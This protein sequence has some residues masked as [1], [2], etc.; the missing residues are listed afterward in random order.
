MQS[1]AGN[2]WAHGFH[3]YGPRV[4]DAAL[5]LI[6]KEAEACDFLGGFVLQQSMAGGTGAGL[7]TYVAQALRDEYHSSHIVNC[8][9]WPYE[10]GE[11]IVQSYNTLLTLSH[12]ADLSD[13]IVL[14]Q[15]EALHRLC[16]KLYNIQRPSFTDMNA[17]A[18]RALA[19]VLLPSSHRPAGGK[20]LQQPAPGGGKATPHSHH[21]PQPAGMHTPQGL[22]VGRPPL[23]SSSLPCTPYSISPSVMDRLKAMTLQQTPPAPSP[24]SQP[25]RVPAAMAPLLQQGSATS[26]PPPLSGPLQLLPDLVSHLCCHPHYR[27]LSLRSIPQVPPASIDF[28]TFTWPALLKR[29]RQMLIT[30][31]ILEEGM[32][33]GLVS[34]AG[35]PGGPPGSRATGLNRSL[36]NWMVLRGQAAGEVD[37]SDFE[38]TGLHP[39]WAV[40]PLMVTSSPHRFNKCAMAAAM[41]S[42]DQGALGPMQRMQERAYAMLASRAFVHQYEKYGLGVPDFEE[43][44]SH[45][46]DMTARYAEL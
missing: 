45:V 11:V 44:F 27:L 22:A 14:M 10:S 23:P 24:S 8:C 1:G 42:N 31:S 16:V 7:G 30:G 40:N 29:M 33:W 13:G 26:P 6:R 18:A 20:V 17:I 3:G 12:L 37:V 21:T 35:S 38:D 46:E 19:S 2:N 41:L 43:C 4:H 34:S 36:A 32:D 25:S 15:N 5:D 28:T 39:P 9:V